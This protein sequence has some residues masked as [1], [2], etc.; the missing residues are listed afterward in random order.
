MICGT[1]LIN[2]SDAESRERNQTV[3]KHGP[4]V[5]CSLDLES[6]RVQDHSSDRRAVRYLDWLV[7]MPSDHLHLHYELQAIEV[8]VCVDV[9]PQIGI[10]SAADRDTWAIPRCFW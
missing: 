5:N 1:L 9:Q 10:Y 4:N 2:F 6:R 8:L 7:S 3:W